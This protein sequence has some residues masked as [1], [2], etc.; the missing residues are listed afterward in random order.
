MAHAEDFRQSKPTDGAPATQRTD[1]YLGYDQSNIYIVWLCHD[2]SPNEIRSQLTKRENAIGDDSVEVIF[3]T[4]KDQRRG[5]VFASNPVGVQS[6]GLWSE[7]GGTDNSWDT[8][9]NTNGRRTANGYFVIMSIPFRS[10]RFSHEDMQQW[11]FILHRSIP[12]NNEETFWPFVSSKINGRLNQSGTLTGLDHI[13]PGRNIEV[14]PYGVWHASRSLNSLDTPPRFE[15]EKLGGRMGTDAKIVLKDSLVL[16][17]TV[18]PDFSQIESDE[19]QI[20]VNQRF[21]VFFPE[22][23]PFFLENSNYFDTPYPLLYTRNI[24]DPEYGARLTGKLGKVSLGFIFANDRSPGQSVPATDPEFGKK[25]TFMI[26][27]VNYDILK[28]STIGLIYTDREFDGSF[29]RVGG[30]DGSFKWKKNYFATFQALVTSTRDLVGNY[31]AG[32]AFKAGGG[33]SGR[34]FNANTYFEDNSSGYQ[35]QVGF[36]SRPDY[37]R[38]S[39]FINY[40]WRPE[41]KI[42]VSFGPNLFEGTNWDH[43]GL[44]L[45]YQFNPGFNF[46]FKHNTTL[47]FFYNA[48]RSHLRPKD[49]NTLTAVQ[50]Y[51]NG[52]RGFYLQSDYF[53]KVSFNFQGVWGNTP[54]VIPA[55][56]GPR[57]AFEQNFQVSVTV[58]PINQFQITTTYLGDYWQDTIIREQNLYNTHIIRSKWNYQIN[59]E[60]SVRFIGQYNTNLARPAFVA[61]DTTKNFNYDLLFTWLLHPGTALYVGYNTNLSTLDPTLVNGPNG[62]V[63]RPN[64]FINDGRQIFVKASYLFRF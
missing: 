31:S 5:Y 23:R 46:E 55:T 14:N 22:K 49:Y 34:R 16:D 61:L 35:T 28:Q 19:P 63:Q 10:L 1:A 18:K 17:L 52:G 7:D 53:K 24:V 42:L 38:F 6:E 29:N 26:G 50:D 64:V 56:G 8:V 32:P 4:Y 13:S 47:N 25:A 51:A 37:I 43:S 15:G 59:K 11:G 39:N 33:Y 58:K 20:T 45:D 60:M 48:A 40:R 54:N 41:G 21:P 12:R 9:W 3:D 44:R 30:I 36:Y 2:S 62:F 27:R 57:D